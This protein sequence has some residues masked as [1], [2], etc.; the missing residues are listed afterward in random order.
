MQLGPP[1]NAAANAVLY[2]L[3]SARQEYKFTKLNKVRSIDC[4]MS[5][6]IID[7]C[8]FN[9]KK[10]TRVSNLF[11]LQ[12]SCFG[13]TTLG[14]KK[15]NERKIFRRD[16]YLFSEFEDLFLVPCSASKYSTAMDSAT[17]KQKIRNGKL[18]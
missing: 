14:F 10:N 5:V 17:F 1:C 4:L 6:N 18:L 12:S 16:K 13:L 15:F 8:E 9:E 3:Y 7:N 11:I 2:I